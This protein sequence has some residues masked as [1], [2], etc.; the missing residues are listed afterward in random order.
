[1]VDVFQNF[2]KICLKI[3]DLD[4]VKFIST[5]RLVWQADLKKTEVKL[6]LL[7]ET[8]MLLMIEKD[9]RGGIYHAI[10]RYAKANNKHV[11]DYNENKSSSYLKYWDVNSFYGWSNVARASSK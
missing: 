7:T 9:I 8:D 2:C 1:M 5:P 3:Y 11:K 4:P 10:Y 6:E